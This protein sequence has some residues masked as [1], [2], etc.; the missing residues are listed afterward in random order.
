[1]RRSDTVRVAA[2]PEIAA[3][4]DHDSDAGSAAGSAVTVTAQRCSTE[5]AHGAI[6]EAELRRQSSPE[7]T[8]MV[9]H[10]LTADHYDN[11][12]N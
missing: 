12:C 8:R 6:Y 4:S 9:F 11:H 1:M 7:T 5:P 10:L 2:R 3:E